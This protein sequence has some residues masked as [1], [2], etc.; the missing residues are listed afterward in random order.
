MSIFSSLKIYADKWNVKEER[1]FSAEEIAEVESA[2]VVESNFGFSVCFEMKQG[3][4]RYIPV[5]IESN[6]GIGQV[7]DLSTAKLLTLCKRGEA[8]IFRVKI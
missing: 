8:D 7:V 6:V 3:G 1:A 4:Q 2:T 5:D